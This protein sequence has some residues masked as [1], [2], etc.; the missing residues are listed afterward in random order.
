MLFT[1]ASASRLGA[2]ADRNIELVIH[3]AVIATHIR[4]EPILR[5]LGSLGFEP[6][7][8]GRLAIIG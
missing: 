8:G 6:Y 4:Y 7:S 5:A 2:S 3:A 1:S